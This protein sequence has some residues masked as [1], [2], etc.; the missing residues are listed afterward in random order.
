MNRLMVLLYIN[1]WYFDRYNF[2]RFVYSELRL[3]AN[4]FDDLYVK[5][6]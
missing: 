1:L 4:D 2:E 3:W 6:E 5:D